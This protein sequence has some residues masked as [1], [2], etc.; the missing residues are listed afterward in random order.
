MGAKSSKKEI[1]F[2]RNNKLFNRVEDVNIKNSASNKEKPQIFDKDVFIDGEATPPESPRIHKQDNTIKRNDASNILKSLVSHHL[3]NIDVKHRRKLVETI[4][5]TKSRIYFRKKRGVA[6]SA[7][8]EIPILNLVSPKELIDKKIEICPTQLMITDTERIRQI[9]E[10]PVKCVEKNCK[11]SSKNHSKNSSIKFVRETRS[12]SPKIVEFSDS[13]FQ[14][15]QS[16]ILKGRNG[17]VS[18][19]KLLNDGKTANQ[20]SETKFFFAPNLKELKANNNFKSNSPIP[21]SP[22]STRKVKLRGSSRLMDSPKLLENSKKIIKPDINTELR[23]TP[24]NMWTWKTA[25]GR[26]IFN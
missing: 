22:S 4:D 20:L 10:K 26:L 21:K 12:N 25:K 24:R 2:L 19:F 13:E 15:N 16:S 5:V 18:F 6:K 1:I 7:S 3:K 11:K 23:Q 8:P 14:N 9:F 17:I